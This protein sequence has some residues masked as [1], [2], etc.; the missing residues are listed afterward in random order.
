MIKTLNDIRIQF[1]YERNVPG[2]FVN[3]FNVVTTCYLVDSN[4]EDIGT[5]KAYCLA[6]DQFSKEIGRRISLTRALQSTELSKIG[7]RM[8]WAA[9][10][11]R[12]S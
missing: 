1:R 12:K 8:V 2:R 7:R 9:Y 10:F 3:E 4:D 6:A 11:G 5:G